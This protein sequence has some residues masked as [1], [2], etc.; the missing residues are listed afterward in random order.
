MEITFTLT[1][2]SPTG[3]QADAVYSWKLPTPAE[4]KLRPGEAWDGATEQVRADEEINPAGKKK[5]ALK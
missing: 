5:S 3:G 2:R 1:A 4:W